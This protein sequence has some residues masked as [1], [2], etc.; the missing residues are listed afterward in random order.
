MRF[1]DQSTCNSVMHLQ[2][3]S[4]Y[5]KERLSD[6]VLVI[7][8]KQIKKVTNSLKKNGYQPEIIN[9]TPLDTG[10]SEETFI[11]VPIDDILTDKSVSVTR[12]EFIFPDHLFP[13]ENP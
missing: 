9:E 3:V 5:I 7:S 4:P 10:R 12:S 6:T 13:D 8:D 11:P 1:R 2:E